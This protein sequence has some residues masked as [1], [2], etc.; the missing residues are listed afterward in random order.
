MSGILPR[1]AAFTWLFFDYTLH[2][3][4]EL[5]YAVGRERG[6]FEANGRVLDLAI[7]TSR[8]FR[9]IGGR[10]R[11]VYHRG[12]IEDASPLGAYKRA[13]PADAEGA[14]S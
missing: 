10:W 9:T 5:F 7:R 12:S 3:A 11:Q 4:D 14:A 13:V 6:R 8:V 2:R 1:L